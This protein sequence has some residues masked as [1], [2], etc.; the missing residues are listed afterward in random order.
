MSASQ[1]PAVRV[2]EEGSDPPEPAIGPECTRREVSVEI[3]KSS[4]S[5][6]PSYQE[7][8][9]LVETLNAGLTIY[10]PAGEILFAN[11]RV[12]EWTGYTAEELDGQHAAILVPSE[13]HDQ[14]PA[15]IE[16]IASGD[17]RSRVGVMM[18]K[19]G[20]GIPI[21]SSPRVQEKDGEVTALVNVAMALSDIQTARK[22]GTEPA[23][24]LAGS[25]ARIGHELQTISLYASEGQALVMGALEHPDLGK[26][27]KREFEILRELMT[28]VRVPA[29]A[30]TL[31]ISPH[32][33]RNHLKSIYRKLGVPDQSSLIERVRVLGS[34][35]D[36]VDRPGPH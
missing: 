22:V 3:S 23:T 16:R 29:I 25:L 35:V 7:L 1:S 11:E 30:R 2:D 18:R 17:L 31:F 24:G 6:Q 5:I 12:L 27:T 26:L 33:V 36:A 21:V 34:S 9:N 20:R 19:D 15:E 32:T 28:G 14:I 4:W 10:A 8:F 13:L